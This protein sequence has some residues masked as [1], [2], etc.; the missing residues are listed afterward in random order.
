MEIE[1]NNIDKFVEICNKY[2]VLSKV[3]ERVLIT[4]LQ[5]GDM[6]AKDKLIRHNLKLVISIAKKYIGQGLDFKDCIQEGSLGLVRAADKFDLNKDFKF[7]TYATWWIRQGI[8]R[9][10]R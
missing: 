8:T 3:E 4:K 7:S 2:K 9:S 1:N 10:Y 5:S 6:R